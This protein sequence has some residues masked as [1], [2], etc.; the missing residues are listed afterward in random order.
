MVS[1]KSPPPSSLLSLTVVLGGACILLSGGF[2][3]AQSSPGTSATTNGKVTGPLKAVLHPV[4]SDLG[5]ADADMQRP[6]GT[7]KFTQGKDKID[8]L[9]QIDRL[10]PAES[11]RAESSAMGGNEYP[12]GLHIH[13]GGSCDAT[14]EGDKTIAAGAAGPHFDPGNTKTHK[15]PDGN[16]HAGDLRMVKV[17]SDGTGI[18]ETTST[19][20]TLDQLV[21]KTVVLHANADNYTDNP[22]NGGSGARIACGVIETQ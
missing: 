18:L 1:F 11:E 10:P 13:A 17:K 8:I 9:V 3:G 20:F 14:Q 6:L 5:R 19:R 22:P 7:V 2:A 15:G 4:S 21:G 12:H 16:G